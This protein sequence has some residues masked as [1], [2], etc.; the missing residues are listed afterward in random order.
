MTAR[1]GGKPSSWP[2]PVT[3]RRLEGTKLKVPLEGWSIVIPGGDRSATVVKDGKGRKSRVK[4]LEL[5]GSLRE[6]PERAF[7]NNDWN[8]DAERVSHPG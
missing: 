1:V 2:Y 3:R 4:V 7:L 8:D 5:Q 6:H